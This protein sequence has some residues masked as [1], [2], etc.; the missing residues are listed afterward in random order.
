MEVVAVMSRTPRGDGAR[1]VA[2]EGE[3][4]V[5]ERDDEG[6]EE[7]DHRDGAAVPGLARELAL[8][9][10]V[11]RHGLGG[12]A[13]HGRRDRDHRLEQQGAPIIDRNAQIG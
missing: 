7:Q 12:H 1:E 4:L 6:D 9:H 11:R 5:D 8:L 3:A 13:A 10:H 2:A